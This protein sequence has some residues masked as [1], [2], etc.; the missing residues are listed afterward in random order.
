MGIFEGGWCRK[1]SE[2]T[3]LARLDQIC[4]H[5][6]LGAVGWICY[7]DKRRHC[8][9]DVGVHLGCASSD[10][11]LVPAARRIRPILGIESAS[12]LST[13]LDGRNSASIFH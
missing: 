4:R 1:R 6:T 12:L 9:T 3:L 2:R 5:A 10:S 8:M 13:H 11:S 7:S